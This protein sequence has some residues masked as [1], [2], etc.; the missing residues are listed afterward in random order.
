MKK[1]SILSIV[2]LV[3][4]S[5][6]F[7]CT[8]TLDLDEAPPAPPPP[9]PG[10]DINWQSENS[11]TLEITNGS[12]KDMILFSGQTPGG[13]SSRLLGGIRAG[14]T[15]LF[16]V[17]DDVSDFSVGGYMVIR[18]VSLDQYT[19]FKDNLPQ[20][21][22][23]FSAMATYKAGTKY[24]LNINPSYIGDYG[25][26]VDNVA[27]VGIE[28]RKDSPRGEKV[29]YLPALQRNQ[30]VYTST[31]DAFALYPTYVYYNTSTGEVS[32]I[33]TTDIFESA[34]A[35][36]RSLANASTFQ[37]YTFPKNLSGWDGIV[38]KLTLPYGYVTVTNNTNESVYFTIAGGNALTSQNGFNTVAVGERSMYEVIG[39]DADE[40]GNGGAEYQ[41]VVTAYGGMIMIPV[42][43]EGEPENLP[44]IKNAYDYEISVRQKSGTTG[45]LSTD[46]TAFITEK[47]KRDLSG[48]ITSL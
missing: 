47:K 1:T 15:K 37:R 35:S 13:A 29:A 40:D 2:L 24:R 43:F 45:R 12:N 42:Y 26:I 17:S 31:S 18:G 21:K 44:K 20:A 22:I 4:M 48:L 33:E 5:T 11:G 3:A 23:D 41:F 25:F 7:G 30:V 46:Y 19:E 28:L 32:T 9:E 8:A 6:F 27:P 38:N 10:A 16:D 34:T 14:G 36:P 39:D